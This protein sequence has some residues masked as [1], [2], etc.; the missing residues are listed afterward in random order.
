MRLEMLIHAQ[1]IPRGSSCLL[2]M[3]G[4]CNS[5]QKFWKLQTQDRPVLEPS[6][7]GVGCSPQNRVEGKIAHLF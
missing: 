1:G 3:D 6:H 4:V 7:K 2:P 5:L